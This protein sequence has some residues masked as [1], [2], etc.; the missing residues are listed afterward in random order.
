MSPTGHFIGRWSFCTIIICIS[1]WFSFRLSL[2]K[3]RQNVA[4]VSFPVVEFDSIGRRSLNDLYTCDWVL[5]EWVFY[6]FF[7]SFLLWLLVFSVIFITVAGVSPNSRQKVASTNCLLFGFPRLLNEWNCC[8]K[9][10]PNE[11]IHC[12]MENINFL[13]RVSIFHRATISL[14]RVWTVGWPVK[15][16]NFLLLQK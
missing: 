9:N 1:Y 10:D 12:D 3:R 4:T 15:F 13:S 6:S 8:T 16:N 5:T 7:F 2:F 14:K 11:G